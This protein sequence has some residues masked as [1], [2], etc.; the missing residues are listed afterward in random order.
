MLHEFVRDCVVYYLDDDSPEVRKAAAI[1]SCQL[2]MRD[3]ICYQTSNHAIEVMGDVL[4][5]LLAVGV[6]DPNPSIREVVLSRLDER[7]DQHLAQAENIRSLFL[8]LNDEVF[9]I[10]KIAMSILGRLAK[11]NPAYVIPS[12][13]KTLIQ[14]LTELEYSTVT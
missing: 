4:E 9:A 3:P 6:A 11:H 10:R 8:A 5:R 2:F 12:L 1:T 13:R 7:F 14:V